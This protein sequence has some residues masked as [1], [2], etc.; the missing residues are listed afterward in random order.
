[1]GLRYLKAKKLHP[2]ANSARVLVQRQQYAKAILSLMEQGK[3]IINIDETWLNET[4]F[5]RKVWSKNKGDGNC[6]LNVVTPRLSMIAAL[7][8]DGRVWFSLSH[9]TTDGDMITLFLSQL[10][11]ML[12]DDMPG[13]EED[14]VILWDNAPYH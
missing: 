3:R 7:D 10:I 11:K 6:Y 8:T 14:T 2:N 1:M 9:A 13:W 5:I 4:S 12:D